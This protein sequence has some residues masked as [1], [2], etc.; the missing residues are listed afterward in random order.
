MCECPL[1][2]STALTTPKFYFRSSPERELKS[3]IGPCRFRART[4]PSLPAFSRSQATLG[5]PNAPTAAVLSCPTG[6]GLL[7]R[8]LPRDRRMIVGP[9]GTTF[10]VSGFGRLPFSTACPRLGVVNPVLAVSAVL[11]D[12]LPHWPPSAQHT[13]FEAL[14][15]LGGTARTRYRWNV[16][17]KPEGAP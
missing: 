7:A 9:P 17:E 13:D 10:G 1:R 15:K 2:V 8:R 11:W 4:G 3:D 6:P 14:T 16:P 12:E 5:T